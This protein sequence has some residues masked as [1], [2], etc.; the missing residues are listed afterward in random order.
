MNQI[1]V[2]VDQVFSIST[3]VTL[4]ISAITSFLFS[5]GTNLLLQKTNRKG[6]LIS[7]KGFE[8]IDQI[9]SIEEARIQAMFYCTFITGF[10]KEQ[11]LEGY[12]KYSD[13][14]NEYEKFMKMYSFILKKSTK[15][16]LDNYNK[17]L[18]QPLENI[19]ILMNEEDFDTMITDFKKSNGEELHN[20]IISLIKKQMI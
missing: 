3:A 7:D 17:Y 16:K 13:E 11:Y 8:M 20:E 1:E 10:T 12:K 4:V 19:R 6:N 18:N 2:I 9:L 5:G 14:I 15:V